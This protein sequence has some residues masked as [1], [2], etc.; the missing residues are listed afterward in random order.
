MQYK[1]AVGVEINE[2]DHIVYSA[3]GGALQLGKVL[4]LTKQSIR[5][6]T[7]PPK[8]VSRNATC[9]EVGC[10]YYYSGKID[11]CPKKTKHK[12][13]DWIYYKK[14]IPAIK[15]QGARKYA[16]ADSFTKM[17]ESTLTKFEN[18]IVLNQNLVVT[19]TLL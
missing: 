3:S 12:T 18:L 6:F 16:G 4:K 2:G 19:M 11:K 15:V 1:D 5:D 17:N 13:D 14:D 7:K 8:R 10:Q 9:M